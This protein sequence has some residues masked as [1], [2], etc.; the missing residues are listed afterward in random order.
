MAVED[1]DME[2]LEESL[3]ES[4]LDE[5]EMRISKPNQEEKTCGSRREEGGRD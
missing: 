3:Y 5:K 4:L 1:D 2:E